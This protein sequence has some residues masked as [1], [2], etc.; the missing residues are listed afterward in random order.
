MDGVTMK[1]PGQVAVISGGSRGIG[2]AAVRMFVQAGA[3]VVFNYQ[4]RH[5]AADALV[6]ELGAENCH[7]VQAD[8]STVESAERLIH[9]AVQRFSGCDIVVA[10]HGIWPPDDVPV[11]VMTPE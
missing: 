7:A 10:N 4:R 9:A 11:D 1:L 8:L 5:E 3:K 6:K 2:A